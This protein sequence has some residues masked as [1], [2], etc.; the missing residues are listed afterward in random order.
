MLGKDKI[1][2]D[3]S[4]AAETDNI[5]AY[6][7]SADGTLLTHTTD[8]SKERLDVADASNKAEDVAHSSGD[9]GQFVLAVRADSNG[10]L[11]DTDGDYAPLQVDAQ[12]F[13]KVIA[14]VSLDS[15]YAEDSAHTT[16][17]I[18]QFILGVRQDADTSP[19]SADGDYHGLIFDNAGRL[20]VAADISVV[21]GFEKLEDAAHSSGDVGG[22]MLS[23]RQDVL[24]TSTDA[25]GDYQ[26]FKTDSLGRLWTNV[27]R[28]SKPDG[29]ASGQY[30]AETV[31]VTA[32]QLAATPLTARKKLLIQN[33]STNR[34][35]YLGFD[36]LV[37]SA[38]GFRL[39]SGAAMELDLSPGLDLYAIANLASADVRI[40]ELA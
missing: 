19:V 9:V 26:S 24:A 17:A 11:V 4:A 31:G 15:E 23:V 14:S 6:L 2:F 21:S 20:K 18:G 28:A 38:N 30:A 34:T 1:V 5:G 27:D 32:V 29:F 16:G 37:T 3:P 13:L 33:V 7:R 40:I 22:Y 10:S 8:G 12:G 39:S 25:D 35:V 36:N